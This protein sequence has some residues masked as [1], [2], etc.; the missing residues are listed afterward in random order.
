MTLPRIATALVLLALIAL[1]ARAGVTVD[2]DDKTSFASYSTWGWRPGTPAKSELV[3][4]RIEKLVTEQL[5]AKGLRVAE[6]SP[7]LFVVT[8]ASSELRQELR[9]NDYGYSYGPGYYRWGS[10]YH[11][12]EVD[13]YTY[14][15]GTLI[16]D[17]VDAKTG[18]LVW[19]GEG[20]DSFN[21]NPD[22]QRVEKK[23]AKVLSR[24]FQSYPPPARK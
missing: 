20:T 17:L 15:Q 6:S 23:I 18:K 9:V 16:V 14:R 13:T 8:H 21:E 5:A 7:D 10:G 3:Q 2:W 22:P 1:P 12:Y 4:A 19:R 24:M 11:G